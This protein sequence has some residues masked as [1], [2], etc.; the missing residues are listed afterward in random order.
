MGRD[1]G[2]GGGGAGAGAGTGTSNP[3]AK[4]EGPFPGSSLAGYTQAHGGQWSP[5]D[6]QMCVWIVQT[7]ATQ[8]YTGRYLGGLR[9]GKGGYRKSISAV[10]VLI[11]VEVDPDVCVSGPDR[12]CQGRLVLGPW[13]RGL[14]SSTP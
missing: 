14:F 6:F 3:W 8:L 4:R 10:L 2:H 11:L 9:E 13:K 7:V 5:G 12:G 1:R